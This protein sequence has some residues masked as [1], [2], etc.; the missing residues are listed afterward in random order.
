MADADPSAVP[1]PALPKVPTGLIERVEDALDVFDFEALAKSRVSPSHWEQL[2]GG[3]DDNA[4]VRVNETAF[5]RLQLRPRRFIDTRVVDTKLE[6]LGAKLKSPIILAPVAAQGLFDAQ[7]EEATARASARRGQIFVLSGT[8]SRD[9]GAVARAAGDP[10]LVWYQMYPTNDFEVTTRLIR[11]VEEAGCSTLVLST[12]MATRGNRL[13]LARAART[14]SAQCATCHGADVNPVYPG[15]GSLTGYLRHFP[16]F[17]DLDLTNVKAAIVPITWELFSK[18]RGI[19]KLRIVLKGVMTAED[20]TLAVEHGADGVWVSNHGG[21]QENSGMAPIEALEEVVHVIRKRLPLIVDGGVRRGVD[22][23]KG[24]ALGA[25]AIAVGR[26]QAWALGSF[27]EAGV[28]RLLEILDAELTTTLKLCGVTHVK[29]VTS[30][31]V[32][33]RRT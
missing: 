12:D 28:T 4:T 32:R 33:W 23:V 18:I 20:T 27:G 15:R 31:H 13:S 17:A 1:L 19:T 7:A 24:L 26:P 10:S 22:V 30:S 2:M 14:D 6:L 11:K 9:I 16:M 3:S 5:S 25:D 21:R 8:A 29:G